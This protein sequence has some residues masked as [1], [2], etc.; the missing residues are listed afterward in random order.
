[1]L[2]LARLQDPRHPPH[3]LFI[4][5]IRF[6]ANDLTNSGQEAIGLYEHIGGKAVVNA[7]ADVFYRKTWKLL[8]ARPDS[9]N[10]REL[11]E[12]SASGCGC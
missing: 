6:P 2:T 7:A 5:G 12:M 1:M 8:Q 4:M 11:S 3:G 10:P 9:G